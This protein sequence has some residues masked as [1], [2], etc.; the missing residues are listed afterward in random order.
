MKI[1]CE[2]IGLESRL[3]QRGDKYISRWFLIIDLFL[4]LMYIHRIELTLLVWSSMIV[5][6][7]YFSKIQYDYHCSYHWGVQ[8]IHW[9]Y[10]IPLEV[11]QTHVGAEIEATT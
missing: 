7:F 9:R 10:E 3:R 2:T 5:I 1:T 8:L 4:I 6:L 11:I